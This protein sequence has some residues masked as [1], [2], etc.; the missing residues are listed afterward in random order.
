MDINSVK[1]S[2]CDKLFYLTTSL[3]CSAG[4]TSCLALI[5]DYITDKPSE[6]F[7]RE[8]LIVGYVLSLCLYCAIIKLQKKARYTYIVYNLI[9]EA[10]FVF[11]SNDLTNENLNKK[12]KAVI[13]IA[14]D[15][16]CYVKNFNKSSEGFEFIYDTYNT[17]LAKIAQ[18]IQT[19]ERIE[20]GQLDA[21]DYPGLEAELNAL[22]DVVKAQLIL[23]NTIVDENHALRIIKSSS[24]NANKEISKKIKNLIAI[25][26]DINSA[27]LHK[28]NNTDQ[29][30][31]KVIEIVTR[32]IARVLQ[33]HDRIERGQLDPSDYP[34]LEAELNA[35]LDVVK[36]ELIL[37]SKELIRHASIQI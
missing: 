13:N 2:L 21:S 9:D 10:L 14:D 5:V 26:S 36:A 8:W 35:L 12:I 22:L 1:I 31:K 16:I 19:Y 24:Y 18:L 30:R 29:T 32:Q 6:N 23:K 28:T 37:Q 33:T 4:F 15:V 17:Y 3:V 27:Y 34:G 20:G 11:R 25:L 7:L